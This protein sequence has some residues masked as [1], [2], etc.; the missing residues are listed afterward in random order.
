[1]CRDDAGLGVGCSATLQGSS[2]VHG[3]DALLGTST[4]EVGRAL[5]EQSLSP[6]SPNPC[7]LSFFCLPAVRRSSKYL[8]C[9][10]LFGLLLFTCHS[11]CLERTGKT[12]S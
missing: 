9:L 8:T 12:L 10:G 11:N 4:L 2:R 6:L 7:P 1:M 3:G 5:A